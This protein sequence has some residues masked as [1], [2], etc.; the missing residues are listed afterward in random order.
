MASPCQQY[1]PAQPATQPA[2]HRDDSSLAPVDPVDRAPAEW[3]I[4]CCSVS[5]EATS[6]SFSPTT[7]GGSTGVDVRTESVEGALSHPSN[8]QLRLGGMHGSPWR[9]SYLA[10][11]RCPVRPC[12]RVPTTALSAFF[13]AMQTRTA[14]T[15][16]TLLDPGPPH[17]AHTACNTLSTP[18]TPIS[19]LPRPP[20]PPAPSA[21]RLCPLPPL[22]PSYSSP[23]ALPPH[24]HSPLP[25]LTNL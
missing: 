18:P 2:T 3:S 5:T 6:Y 25:V 24:L 10:G 23:L 9:R 13:A 15:V 22:F 14:R 17:P 12:T 16:G 11:G 7:C 1:Q 8:G 19:P 4:S 21:S 20:P